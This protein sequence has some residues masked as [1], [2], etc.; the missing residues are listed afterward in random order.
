M[1]KKVFG[2]TDYRSSDKYLPVLFF[3]TIDTSRRV[4]PIDKKHYYLRD[5]TMLY[6]SEIL[7]DVERH[8]EEKVSETIKIASGSI[9]IAILLLAIYLGVTD[10]VVSELGT[11][12]A[13]LPLISFAIGRVIYLRTLYREK[14][15]QEALLEGGLVH[16]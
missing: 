3:D 9:G 2:N 13:G 6:K 16:K 7:L 8:V 12:L 5:N 14:I 1:R 4:N 15:L 11:A 10:V